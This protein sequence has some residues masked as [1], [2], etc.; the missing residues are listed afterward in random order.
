MSGSNLTNQNGVY[1]TKGIASTSNILGAR[2]LTSSWIDSQNNIWVFG[3]F[4]YDKVGTR[5]VSKML[6]K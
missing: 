6:N 1:G 4:G 3:G 5:T 2:F